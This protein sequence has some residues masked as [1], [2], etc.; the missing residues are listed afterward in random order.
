[1]IM[2]T[3]GIGFDLF[4]RIGSLQ[5][6]A[7]GIELTAVVFAY[8]VRCLVICLEI[9]QDD[10]CIANSRKVDRSVHAS[11]CLGVEGIFLVDAHAGTGFVQIGILEI[12]QCG[13][14][15]VIDIRCIVSQFYGFF[16]DQISIPWSVIREY[17]CQGMH[18]STVGSAAVFPEGQRRQYI[19]RIFLHA[20]TLQGTWCDH[21]RKKRSLLRCPG[22]MHRC[23][24]HRFLRGIHDFRFFHHE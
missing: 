13:D 15:T 11:E 5:D 16:A 21:F 17:F 22:E 23:N 18:H 9:D 7:I 12:L 10:L 6:P 24:V 8:C 3:V 1:M 14:G 19:D 2:E 4:V 20:R